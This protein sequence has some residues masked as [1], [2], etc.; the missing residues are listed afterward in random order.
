MKHPLICSLCPEPYLAKGLCSKCYHRQYYLRV[1]EPRLEYREP[2]LAAREW[3]ARHK[4]Y[5]KD[6]RQHPDTRAHVLELEAQ[7]RERNSEKEATRRAR[8]R[9]CERVL[10]P[11]PKGWK[12][13]QLEK[14]SGKCAGC[15]KKFKGIRQSTID[16]IRP[17]VNG[18]TNDPGNL[19]LL[20]FSCNSSK[21]AKD[22]AEWRR[23]KF[24]ALL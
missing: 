2:G 8:R 9:M 5:A 15:R 22:E 3:R 21:R 4:D 7:S 11:I 16:H 18:G 20:C 19:Q 1:R 24:G 23:E 17:L 10:G 12:A 13:A 14:Q 6:R